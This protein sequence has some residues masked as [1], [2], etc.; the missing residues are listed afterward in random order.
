MNRESK[1]VII[2]AS[3]ERLKAN[4]EPSRPYI[5]LYHNDI[6]LSIHIVFVNSTTTSL[7]LK[8]NNGYVKYLHVQNPEIMTFRNTIQRIIL[9]TNIKSY[10]RGKANRLYV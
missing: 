9:K 8:K 1:Q 4:Q 7:D 2:S 5:K 10:Y 3:Q 6:F